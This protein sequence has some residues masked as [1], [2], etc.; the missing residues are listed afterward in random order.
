MRRQIIDYFSTRPSEGHAPHIPRGF[1]RPQGDKLST[2]TVLDLRMGQVPYF[3]RGTPSSIRRWIIRL[4]QYSIF[5][6]DKFPISQEEFFVHETTNC[7]LLRYSTF[8]GTFSPF[9]K[10]ILSSMRRLFRLL[11]YSILGRDQ[12]P[13]SQKGILFRPWDGNWLSTPVFN[14]R[15]GQ[16]PYT[17]KT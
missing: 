14:L 2:T 16:G 17:Q 1:S 4:L 15:T 10:K 6:W 7:R 5:E 12:L 9:P 3:Q 8:R 11:R 13:I